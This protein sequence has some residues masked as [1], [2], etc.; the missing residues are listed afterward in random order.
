M[1]HQRYDRHHAWCGLMVVCMTTYAFS[2]KTATSVYTGDAIRTVHVLVRSRFDRVSH[3]L[4][5]SMHVVARPEDC[6]LSLQIVKCALKHI[7]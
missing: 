4:H 7:G 2:Y 1:G 5:V 3:G 6:V